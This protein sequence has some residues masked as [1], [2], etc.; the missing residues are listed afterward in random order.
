MLGRS[1]QRHWRATGEL[2]VRNGSC[3]VLTRSAFQYLSAGSLSGSALG[4]QVVALD[5]G[6][7]WL[8]VRR[9]KMDE[10]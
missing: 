8:G 6:A 7:V 9:Q 3:T 4:Q 2:A 1:N 5:D 10:M